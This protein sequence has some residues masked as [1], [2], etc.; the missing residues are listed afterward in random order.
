MVP[1]SFFSLRLFDFHMVNEISTLID[2]SKTV[3]LKYS[4]TFFFLDC[5]YEK[6]CC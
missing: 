1:N 4:E 3:H 5:I 2:F 6:P